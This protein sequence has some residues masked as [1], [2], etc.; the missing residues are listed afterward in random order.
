MTGCRAPGGAGGRSADPYQRSAVDD[1]SHGHMTA[2]TLI[3]GS[4]PLSPNPEH[5]APN[6][7]AG[8]PV[9]QRVPPGR[10]RLGFPEVASFLENH[11]EALRNQD[12]G[13]RP[14]EKIPKSPVLRGDGA[15]QV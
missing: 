7:A 4:A 12:D 5:K 3:H 11:R 10:F 1:P 14:A 6:G 9:V 13:S 2:D 8:G 15:L